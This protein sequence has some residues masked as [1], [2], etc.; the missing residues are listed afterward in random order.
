MTKEY[1]ECIE[2]EFL[3]TF[4]TELKQKELITSILLFIVDKLNS[5]ESLHGNYVFEVIS[6]GFMGYYPVIGVQYKDKSEKV[7]EIVI[8]LFKD[9]I[10]K[11][12]LANFIDFSLKNTGLINSIIKEIENDNTSFLSKK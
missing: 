10:E 3:D 7:E 8:S 12:S 4:I 9:Y 2:I 1:D 6:Y 5:E 11:F